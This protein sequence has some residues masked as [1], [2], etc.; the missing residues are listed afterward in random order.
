MFRPMIDRR[1]F[2]TGLLAGL[3]TTAALP[4][5]AQRKGGAQVD[6][7]AALARHPK[8]KGARIRK[9]NLRRGANT[10]DGTL[11]EVE[12][13]T[14]DRQRYLVYI[15]PSSDRVLYDTGPLR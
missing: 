8:Y 12:I 11:Y 4:A 15:D 13:E 7:G 9:V 10:P 14:P 6:V 5:H 2:V 3:A 1:T